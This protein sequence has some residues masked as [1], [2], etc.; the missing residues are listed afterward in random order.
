MAAAIHHVEAP[1]ATL[2]SSAI[3]PTVAARPAE[4]TMV[5]IASAGHSGS[6]LLDLLLANHTKVSS[7][8]EM[9]RL[10][11]HAPDRVCACGATVTQCEYWNAV[12]GTIRERRGE[13][14]PLRWE[15]CHTDVPP[16]KPLLQIAGAAET[17]L[18]EGGPVPA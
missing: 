17:I 15:Q 7:A 16:Q 6:T 1:V 18:V 4:A 9:N 10:T 3:A 8:G 12:R 14:A 13:T 2:N 11:L 5:L